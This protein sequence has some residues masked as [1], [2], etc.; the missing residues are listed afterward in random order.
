MVYFQCELCIETLKKKQVEKHHFVCRGA[1]YY[2]CLT[3]HKNFDLETIKP[4][5]AC[6]TEEEKYQKGD[7]NYGKDKNFK[8]NQNNHK[9][10]PNVKPEE[11][12]WKGFRKT[13]REVLSNFEFKKMD[14]A[15]FKEFLIKVY[16]NSQKV[17]VD[18]IDAEIFEK[19]MMDKYEDS[20]KFVMDLSK[21]TIRYK[22]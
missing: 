14:I 13:G 3:C 21:N 15:K 11:F 22:F 19:R 12:E 6:V 8:H 9:V 7:M 4:H 18:A 2:S 1:H 20:N 17:G 5:T 16:A 10:N